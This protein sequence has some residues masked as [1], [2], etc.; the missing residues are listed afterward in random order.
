MIVPG[1]AAMLEPAHICGFGARHLH[2]V[3]A[4]V[5]CVLALALRVGALGDDQRPGDQGRRFARPAGLDRQL[6]E[7]DIVAGPHH[8]VHRPRGDGLGAH[9][10]DRAQEWQLV[11]G[12]PQAARRF[13]LAQEGEGL[14]HL[15]QLVR[16]AIHAPGDPLDGAEQIGEHRDRAGRPVV[17]DDV[18]EQHRRAPLGEQAGL[19]LGHLEVRGDRVIDEF[20]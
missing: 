18:F 20:A 11:P 6:A 14:T 16:L 2:P 12:V 8:L 17:C 4:Q 7:I 10:H 15:G 5:E 13:G 3:D 19:D 1:S 9:G